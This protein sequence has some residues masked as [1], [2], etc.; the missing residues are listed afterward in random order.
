MNLRAVPGRSPEDGLID[1]T[2][3]ATEIRNLIRAVPHP[4]PGAFPWAGEREVKIWNAT[5][6]DG[7]GMGVGK[8]SEMIHLESQK[9]TL[10]MLEGIRLRIVQMTL[11]SSKSAHGA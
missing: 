6:A 11:T 5:G 3:S 2:R 7:K 4:W 10:I 1:W 9:D 8:D